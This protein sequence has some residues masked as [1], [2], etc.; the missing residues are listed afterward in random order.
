MSKH[1]EKYAWNDL[2]FLFRK[3]DIEEAHKVFN[4][5]GNTWTIDSEYVKKN[6]SVDYHVENSNG[7]IG[8]KFVLFYKSSAYAILGRMISGITLFCSIC[9]VLYMSV[10][11]KKPV[12]RIEHPI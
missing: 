6:Y 8:V 4:E 3:P 2:S 12:L 10:K 9:Y 11:K 7:S 1:S 5:F